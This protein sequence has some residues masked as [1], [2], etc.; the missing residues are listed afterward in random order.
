M[1]ND[2]MI[3]FNVERVRKGLLMYET[4]DDFLVA[5]IGS[6]S[7]PGLLERAEIMFARN[8]ARATDH[9][10]W[11]EEGIELRKGVSKMEVLDDV[12][13]VQACNRYFMLM[14]YTLTEL[15]ERFTEDEFFFLASLG[16]NPIWQ[17]YTNMFVEASRYYKN[18]LS[19]GG[20]VKPHIEELLAKL[21]HLTPV[22]NLALADACEMVW[23]GR[24]DIWAEH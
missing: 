4:M 16:Y 22:E 8:S 5:Q 7:L 10:E 15:K 6:A 23:R 21:K 20:E 12:A 3:T 2:K 17:T 19:A 9:Y 1:Q 24:R 18:H 14:Q 11:F 13:A